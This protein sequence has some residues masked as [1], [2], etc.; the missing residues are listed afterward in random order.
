[1]ANA[2]RRA[3]RANI[4]IAPGNRAV[5]APVAGRLFTDLV[6]TTLAV[7]EQAALAA[8]AELAEELEAAA[9][10]LAEALGQSFLSEATIVLPP[11]EAEELAALEA[12]E[13]ELDPLELEPAE[14]ELAAAPLATVAELEEL[15]ADALEAPLPDEAEAAPDAPLEAAAPP[16]PLE[17]TTEELV[18]LVELELVEAANTV[19]AKPV[20]TITPRIEIITL[21]IIILLYL[22]SSTFPTNRPLVR[23]GMIRAAH[24]VVRNS[25]R[26]SN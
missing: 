18:E 2:K 3:A 21:F 26:I 9:A 17:T 19:P 4:A 13:P 12:L 20:A 1:M 14:P 11:A 15:A 22:Y 23:H 7:V 16:L 8:A 25:E 24:F 6:V 10:A 5:S